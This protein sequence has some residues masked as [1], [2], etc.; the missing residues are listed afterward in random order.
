MTDPPRPFTLRAVDRAEGYP[1]DLGP[2][3]LAEALRFTGEWTGLDL[4]DAVLDECELDGV[5]IDDCQ[6]R[7]IRI[8]ESV[9]TSL[10]VAALRAPHSQWRE[11]S[12][13]RSRIGSAELFESEWTSV[14]FAASK[15]GY[16]NLRAASLTDVAFDGCTIDELDL[17]RVTASRVS[18]RN[19]S[20]GTLD[21]SG[22]TLANVDLRGAEFSVVNGIAGLRGATIDGLQLSLF[23]PLLAGELGIGVDDS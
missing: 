7:G 3:E 5:V 4:T 17:A 14:R 16:V 1:G 2:R 21:V 22:A 11:V 15:L 19:C 13:D 6:L 10:N 9:I 23:A 8:S 12:V 20:I 18:L